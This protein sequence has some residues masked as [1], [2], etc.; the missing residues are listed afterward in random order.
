MAQGNRAYG[1][2]HYDRSLYDHG[3]AGF[4]LKF[5]HDGFLASL[6]KNAIYEAIYPQLIKEDFLSYKNN[7]ANFLGKDFL[8]EPYA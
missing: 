5:S 2:Y 4:F 6:D 1:L 8:E 3:H 7:L